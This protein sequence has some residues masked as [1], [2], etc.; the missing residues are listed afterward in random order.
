MNK[1]TR[2]RLLEDIDTLLRSELPQVKK[3]SGQ[4][5]YLWPHHFPLV[6]DVGVTWV[7]IVVNISPK[8]L[9][10]FTLIVG[11]S[12]LQRYPEV[13]PI[14]CGLPS[15]SQEEFMKDEFMARIG[16]L[17]GS[18]YWWILS[19]QTTIPFDPLDIPTYEKAIEDLRTKVERYLFPYVRN[20]IDVKKGKQAGPSASFPPS[21]R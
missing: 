18:D 4:T 8:G 6:C 21:E 15:E 10:E 5:E 3:Y 11:W 14:A 16:H 19:D 13:L 1:S 2:L 9:D 7:F 12:D 17:W 20:L